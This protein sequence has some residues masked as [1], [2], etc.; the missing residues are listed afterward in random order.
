MEQEVKP[1]LILEKSIQSIHIP[2]TRSGIAES[3]LIR[4]LKHIYTP[5]FLHFLTSPNN[6]KHETCRRTNC[7]HFPS[8]VHEWDFVNRTYS[9]CKRRLYWIN[10]KSSLRY[11]TFSL[12][13]FHATLG[14]REKISIVAKFSLFVFTKKLRTMWCRSLH[15]QLWAVPGIQG[16]AA[17]FKH[18]AGMKCGGRNAIDRS[19]WHFKDREGKTHNLYSSI[20]C[21]NF[22][23]WK[24]L[25]F[26]IFFPDSI[27]A[28]YVSSPKGFRGQI[29]SANAALDRCR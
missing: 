14:F 7:Q 1:Y 26:A 18:D 16:L 22:S 19:T 17:M 21:G 28:P 3:Q 5:K 9:E 12:S 29:S 25:S 23:L 6:F 8:D 10:S 13:V 4:G 15:I 24:Q 27:W 11:M 2:L 20:A